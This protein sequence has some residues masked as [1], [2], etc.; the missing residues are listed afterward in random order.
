MG[1]LVE[2]LSFVC[3]ALALVLERYPLRFV[4]V[5]SAVGLVPNSRRL[6]SRMMMVASPLLGRFLLVV[7]FRLLM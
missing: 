3:Q 2:P 5:A 7:F 1:F 4:G 6:V